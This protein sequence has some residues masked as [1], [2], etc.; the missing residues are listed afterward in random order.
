MLWPSRVK[1]ILEDFLFESNAL[2]FRTSSRLNS[3]VAFASTKKDIKARSVLLPPIIGPFEATEL[4]L[5]PMPAIMSAASE[6]SIIDS[7]LKVETFPVASSTTDSFPSVIVPVLSLNRM[8]R[9]PAVSRPLIFL[10]RTLSFAI[11]KLWKESRI[12]VSIGR[13]SGTAQTIIVTATVTAFII[14]RIQS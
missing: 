4:L 8:L 1:V 5:I 11:F 12:D 6:W 7:S 14:S 3:L 10:T 9:L 13:P 2:K